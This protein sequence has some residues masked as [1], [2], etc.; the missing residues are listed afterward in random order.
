MT[1]PLQ[2]APAAAVEQRRV[3]RLDASCDAWR[4]RGLRGPC[5]SAPHAARQ[6][7]A[8]GCGPALP[9]QQPICAWHAARLS[10]PSRA[11]S[12]PSGHGVHASRPC[13]RPR[14]AYARAWLRAWPLSGVC[15]RASALPS[16][17]ARAAWRLPPAA[18]RAREARPGCFV[19]CRSSSS[20]GSRRERRAVSHKPETVATVRTYP[21]NLCITMWTDVARVRKRSAPARGCVMMNGFSPAW[22]AVRGRADARQSPAAFSMVAVTRLRPEFLLR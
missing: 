7:H 21:Q 20:V 9:G 19:R 12:R 15:A 17:C 2:G 3:A 14:N 16:Q 11:W 8:S 4:R 18:V 22:P 6:G 10:S 13:G 1:P 5:A